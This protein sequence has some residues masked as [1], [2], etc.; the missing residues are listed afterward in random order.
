MNNLTSKKSALTA[1]STIIAI[2]FSGICW[3]LS[4]GLTGNFWYLLW[5]APIPVLF[6]ALKVSARGA[7]V[8]SFIAYLIG[9]LSWF[10]YL[11]T[12]A[13]II[14]A[15]IFTLML[16]LVFALI[17]LLARWTV[18][19]TNA[20][21]SIFAFPVYFTVFEFL[22]ISF[23]T[24]GS[25]ASIAYSQ[26]NVLS[27]IQ[28]ASV[29]GMLGITF[30]L[31][32]IPSAIA[33]NW[34]YYKQKHSFRLITATTTIILI[35]VFLFGIIRSIQKTKLLS[36]KVG[37]V[38]ADEQLHDL[39][40][41]LN[42]DK[43][44]IA[45]NFYLESID[46]L[47]REG[48]QLIVL[49]ER[50][51]NI[52]KENEAETI[53]RFCEVAKR[54]EVYL[55]IGYSNYRNPKAKNSALVIDPKGSI[56]SDYDKVHLV[57]GL[58]SRF[59]PGK[60]IGLFPFKGIQSGVAVCKDMDFPDFIRNYGKSSV[61]ILAVPA[62][63]FDVDAWLHSRMAILRGVENGF[64]E[65]R[66][67]RQGNLTISDCFGKV[68]Y[69]AD[70]SKGNKIISTAVMQPLSANTLY[71]RWGNWFGIVNVLLAMGFVVLGFLRKK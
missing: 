65:I 45:Q 6:T 38:V 33:V 16:P 62:W 29:T 36:F 52:Y 34:F 13:T 51:V 68:T 60:G 11:V 5:I 58:E 17:V 8:I 56:I 21:Y 49:P 53:T 1:V 26:S 27:V 61:R 71:S 50:A 19:R 57:T 69:E 39:S 59:T 4:N 24:D 10:S 23:S 47:A 35:A 46:S 64:S 28:I 25:A 30:M 9:R 43:E 14:P 12:V 42:P 67:A 40:S 7:F 54:N 2:L 70:C 41:Q 66:V 22:L 48:A 32:L 31:S 18:L 15:I 63:D 20:W 44:A 55:V 37:M 3:Y